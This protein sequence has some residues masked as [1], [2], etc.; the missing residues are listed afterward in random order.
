MRSPSRGIA[1]GFNHARIPR[2]RPRTVEPARYTARDSKTRVSPARVDSDARETSEADNFLCVQF[3]NRSP[4]M[5]SRSFRGV[6]EAE[7]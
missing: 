1:A 2:A 7:E 3:P 6:R 4:E 5:F